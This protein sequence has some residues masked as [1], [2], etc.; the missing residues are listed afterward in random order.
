MK[1]V[2][3]VI[4]IILI[5]LVILWFFPPTHKIIIEFYESNTIVQTI[6]NIVGGIFKGIWNGICSIFVK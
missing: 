6:V 3:K 1:K 5:I 4:G 2:L